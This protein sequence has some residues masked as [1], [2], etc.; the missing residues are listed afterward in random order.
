MSVMLCRL[1]EIQMSEHD[2]KLYEQFLSKVS[3]QINSI[4]LM[5][6]NVQVCLLVSIAVVFT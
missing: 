3:K 6:N 1:K 2:A 4:Q 5:L